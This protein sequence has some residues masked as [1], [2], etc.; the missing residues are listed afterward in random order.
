MSL[1]MSLHNA[2][3]VDIRFILTLPMTSSYF[4]HSLCTLRFTSLT[5]PPKVAFWEIQKTFF[6]VQKCWKDEA[7]LVNKK[8][9]TEID[10][11]EDFDVP[12]EKDLYPS[13]SQLVSL[14]K[15]TRACYL[16]NNVEW[17]KIK[18]DLKLFNRVI[19]KT[20]MD[21]DC[22]FSSILSQVSH[23]VKYTPQML[24]KQCAYFAVKNHE[25]FFPHLSESF[26][27]EGYIS[28]FENLF[29][30]RS[31]GDIIAITVIAVMWNISISI[32]T[33]HTSIIHVYHDKP[34]KPD[35]VLVHNGRVG[36]E[37]HYTSTG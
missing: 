8:K 26:Q 31:Y 27:D 10:P 30:G 4:I 12:Q 5:E 16:K 14:T 37:G 7:L 24:R 35:V 33:P 28:Y 32:V 20:I 29:E 9:S 25:L 11:T 23:P 36:S 1:H 34:Q 6:L 22:L 17:E 18:S 2:Y 15:E 13:R 19:N 21:G 3:N